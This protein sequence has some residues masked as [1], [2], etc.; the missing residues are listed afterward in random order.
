MLSGLLLAESV[1]LRV[2]TWELALNLHVW[3]LSLPLKPIDHS[4]N[5]TPHG[6]THY[7]TD[8]GPSW[9]LLSPQ[10]GILTLRSLNRVFNY[11]RFLQPPVGSVIFLPVGAIRI[12]WPLPQAAPL[13]GVCA[14]LSNSEAQMPDA[15]GIQ[16]PLGTSFKCNKN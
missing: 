10:P 13:S 1:C 6:L 4:Y 9:F 12:S 8:C 15:G 14:L 3:V 11:T 5:Q 7:P 2:L 16:D